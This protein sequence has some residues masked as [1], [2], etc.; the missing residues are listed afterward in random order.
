MCQI[1]KL[2]IIFNQVYRAKIKLKCWYS[3]PQIWKLH[4]KFLIKLVA[5]C[6]TYQAMEATNARAKVDAATKMLKI[7]QITS[8]SH[9]RDGNNHR[10]QKDHV[11]WNQGM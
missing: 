11:L 2:Y 7:I 8:I 9:T 3:N 1:K 6:S 10:T 5:S 4:V